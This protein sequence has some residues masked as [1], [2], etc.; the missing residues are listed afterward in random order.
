MT[1]G[2][3]ETTA[4]GELGF[5]LYSTYLSRPIVLETNGGG[6]PATDYAIDD[7]INASFLFAYGVSD[8]LELDAIAPVTLSQTGSGVSPLSGSSTGVQTSG[9]RD[10]RFGFAYALLPRRRV[11]TNAYEHDLPRPSMFGVTARLELSAPTGSTD[12][13]GSSGYAVWSPSVAADFRRGG[14]FAGTEV[15]L[16]L[17]KTEELQGDRI[18]SQAFLGVGVGY[19]ILPHE[20]LSVA[21]EGY[22]LPTFAEQHTITAPAD[23]I[24]IVSTPNGKYIAPAEWMLSVRSAPLFGGD[25][26]IQAGGGGSIPFSSESPITNPRF[27]F[28][29]SVRRGIL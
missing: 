20:L 28:A 19:D 6:A 21:A 11:D 24:G 25:L 26:Q 2:G 10:F 1:I 9:V 23:T 22:A 15:G 5:G 27:R 16:R 14:I 12:S 7:Q 3:A 18:G 29:L 13:F 17:Q 4:R 8:R